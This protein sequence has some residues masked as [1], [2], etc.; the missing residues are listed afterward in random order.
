MKKITFLGDIMCDESMAR[1]MEL[2]R[3]PATGEYN[4]ESTFIHLTDPLAS[5]DYVIANLETPVTRG[6]HNLTYKKWEFNTPIQFVTAMKKAGI[7]FVSTANNHCLDRGIKGLVDTISCLDE[8]GMGH[9]GTNLS[10]SAERSRLVDLNGLKLGILAYTYGTNAF[11]N[12]C[13]LPFKYR[14]AVNLLQEQEEKARKLYCKIFKNRFQRVF[15]KVDIILFPKNKNKNIYEKETFHLYRKLLIK[16][17]MYRLKKRK[18]DIIIALLHIGGQYNTEPSDYTL[19]VTEWF[20]D[21]GCDIVIGNHEHVIHG[22]SCVHHKFVAYA[23]GD[24][25]GCS[26]ISG[27]HPN[28]RADYSIAVHLFIDETIMQ[29][30]KITFSLL[31]T[32]KT[33]EGKYEVWPV[34]SLKG[35]DHYNERDCLAAAYD[36]SDGLI[37]S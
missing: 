1:T 8:V 26:G 3:E 12:N 5:S 24:C 18:P 16:W 6:T 19:K 33:N 22:S 25:L 13:Y 4:F 11:S 36:F 9:C 15:N 10:S 32:V 17:D 34:A 35:T 30:K 2:Y 20:K 27:N 28:R 14:K 29:L 31:K 21:I 23:L 37:Y 7:S